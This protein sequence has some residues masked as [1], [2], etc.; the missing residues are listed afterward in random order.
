M[1]K[2]IQ[3]NQDKEAA[4]ILVVKGYE[5]HQ[6]G[7][8]R[9]AESF[10]QQSLQQ[11]PN[12]PDTN[13]VFGLL[14]I[15]TGRFDAATK[16]IKRALD[17]QPGNPQS[18]YNLA[19]A[20]KELNHIDAA[21]KHFRKSIFLAPGNFEA[22]NSLGV[23]LREQGKPGESLECLKAAIKL[24]PYYAQAHLNAGMAYQDLNETK[25]AGLC[26]GQASNLDPDM[27]EAHVGLAECAIDQKRFQEALSHSRQALKVNPESSQAHNT[28]GI[29]LN[30]QGKTK[31]AIES[32]ERAVKF[33]STN[34]GALMNLGIALEQSGRLQEAVEFYQKAIKAK[35]DSSRAYYLLAHLKNHDSSDEEI[36]AAEALLKAPKTS[37][38]QRTDLAFALACA[39][40]GKQQYAAS[41]KHLQEGHRLKKK[42]VSFDLETESRY[43]HSLAETFSAEFFA[44]HT[45]KETPD[46]RTVFI[47]G[48]PRSG[49]SLTEQIL[50]SHTS[51]FGAGELSLIAGIG[52]KIAKNTGRPFPQACDDLDQPGIHTYRQD[53]LQELK[54][55]SP[56][57]E[58]ISDTNP[59]NFLYTGLIATLLPNALVINCVRDPMDNC[60]SIYKHLLA[61]PHAYSHD[62]ED[63]GGYFMLY[64][65]LMKH[66]HQ[67]LPGKIYDLPY[68][69][70]VA[71]S[72][73]EIRK[74]LN[75]CALPF[76]ENCLNFHKTSR[77]VRT[78][79]ASQVRQPLYSDTIN[80]WKHYEQQLKPLQAILNPN[81][82]KA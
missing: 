1:T 38:V 47:L 41:F 61:D 9:Q 7:K 34:S 63:L 20:Y 65:N 24:K 3:K 59:M 72:E 14:C 53:Y 5:L 39:F 30:K 10:Y 8:L 66:W 35:P 16:L 70:M 68:E 71:D 40:E 78:P 57:T 33:S 74:L 45:D 31:R 11:N 69:K 79:S 73:N 44:Q 77:V 55:R 27:I 62:L 58:V 52:H 82:A 81:K 36:R 54:K 28:H 80:L 32:F 2:Q 46:Q 6:A 15:Q 49:T 19:I 4:S 12:S 60:L 67:V 17:S 23:V 56:A 51:V 42:S 18:H 25:Q 76:D 75:F 13:N 50:A 48:M 22:L 43:F 29:A 21:E 37:T 26:F 64:K